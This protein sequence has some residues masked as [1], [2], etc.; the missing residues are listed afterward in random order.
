MGRRQS[1]FTL[2]EIMSVLGIM[3]ILATLA[4]PHYV[5]YNRQARAAEAR[6]NLSCIATF[7]QVRE[8][9]RF[10]LRPDWQRLGVHPE[11]RVRYQY[12]VDVEGDGFRVHAESAM[13]NLQGYERF[14][15]SSDDLTVRTRP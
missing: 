15:L 10:E 7:Q 3:S 9:L 1:G 8:P 4:L 11:S 12:R 5:A 2:V 14:E 6:V 13:P